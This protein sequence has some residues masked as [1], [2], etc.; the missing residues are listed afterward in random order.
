M[1]SF[2][3]RGVPLDVQHHYFSVYDADS[4]LEFTFKF[5]KFHSSKKLDQCYPLTVMMKIL[6][7]K[8]FNYSLYY[9]LDR[10]DVVGQEYK[11][12]LVLIALL[13]LLLA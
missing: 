4:I 6:S 1:S 5:Q 13:Q 3:N 9:S 10:R 11:Y 12:S 7:H 8:I 2:W